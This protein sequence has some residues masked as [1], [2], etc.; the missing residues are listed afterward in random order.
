MQVSDV[1]HRI[2][3]EYVPRPYPGRVTLIWGSG[4]QETPEHAAAWWRRLGADV[5]LHVLP[6]THIEAIT[7]DVMNF[8]RELQRCL[9]G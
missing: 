3:D 1:F 9:D 8:A 7:R 2:D 4:E 6:G 5:E